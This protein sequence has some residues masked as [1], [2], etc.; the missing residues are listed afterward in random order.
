VENALT[1]TERQLDEAAERSSSC[2]LAFSGGKDSLVCADLVCKKFAHVEA[3]FMYLIPDLECVEKALEFGRKR[4]GLKLHQFP[5]WMCWRQ[6]KWG[7][8]CHPQPELSDVKLNQIYD[9][10]RTKT[11]IDLIVTGAKDSDSMWRKRQ[12]GTW[13]KKPNMFY[14]IQKWNKLQVLGYLKSHGIPLPDSSHK[15]ATGVDLSDPSLLWLHKNHPSDYARLLREYPFAEAA[16][17]RRE[18]FGEM[19][20]GYF[21]GEERPVFGGKEQ[22]REAIAKRERLYMMAMEMLYDA[23]HGMLEDADDLS[24]HEQRELRMCRWGGG[25]AVSNQPTFVPQY[26]KGNPIVG[27]NNYRARVEGLDHCLT[28]LEWLNIREAFENR[29]AYCGRGD[30]AIQMDHLVPICQRGGTESRNVVPCCARCNRDKSG[31]HPKYWVGERKMV[32][33]QEKLRK[34][35]PWR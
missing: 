19:V 4:W 21:E 23:P 12:L 26:T 5:H 11:G 22:I 7:V 28:D 30:K 24:P 9:M 16:I 27:V 10:A 31:R 29:C 2:L 35:N 32:E 14:P 17:K 6:H 18:F 1:R 34:A 25:P 33:I 8:F 20:E 15:N 3:F 13:G